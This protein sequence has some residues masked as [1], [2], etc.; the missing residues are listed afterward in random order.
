[1]LVFNIKNKIC[2]LQLPGSHSG[3]LYFCTWLADGSM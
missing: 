3:Q 2:G 1:M